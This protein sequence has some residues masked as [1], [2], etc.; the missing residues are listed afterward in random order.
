[1]AITTADFDVYYSTVVSGGV[2]SEAT[3]G[4]YGYIS[5]KGVTFST[6]T[7]VSLEVDYTG[8]AGYT[9]IGAY[10]LLADGDADNSAWYTLAWHE[11]TTA[12]TAVL[13]IAYNLQEAATALN[14]PTPEPRILLEF[15]NCS[16]TDVRVTVEGASVNGALVC[17]DP[18]QAAGSSLWSFYPEACRVFDGVALIAWTPQAEEEYHW[19]ARAVRHSGNIN[20]GT[21]GDTFYQPGS[22]NGNGGFTISWVGRIA[23]GVAVIVVSEA[24]DSTSFGGSAG[25]E[26]GWVVS[27]DQTT[28]EITLLGT[29]TLTSTYYVN[30]SYALIAEGDGRC[31]IYGLNQAIQPDTTA[32]SAMA[33]VAADGSYTTATRGFPTGGD[34]ST[35]GFW[36]RVLALVDMGTFFVRFAQEAHNTTPLTYTTRIYEH[37]HTG[38]IPDGNGTQRLTVSQFWQFDATYAERISDTEILIA[39]TTTSSYLQF[40]VLDTSTW[41]ISGPYEIGRTY[42]ALADHQQDYVSIN[43]MH[44][45]PGKALV[46]WYQRL[47]GADVF[48]WDNGV[49]KSHS[50]VPGSELANFSAYAGHVG[51]YLGSGRYLTVGNPNSG[52]YLYYW[53]AVSLGLTSSNVGQLYVNLSTTQE[54][55]NWVSVC[56]GGYGDLVELP[57]DTRWI[58][59]AVSSDGTA[60]LRDSNQATDVVFRTAT[61]PTTEYGF[62]IPSSDYSA[63]TGAITGIKME[64]DVTAISGNATVR[65]IVNFDSV[66]LS[67]GG[68]FAFEAD[69]AVTGPGTYEVVAT[70]PYYTGGDPWSWD[71]VISRLADTSGG[72]DHAYGSVETIFS[73]GGPEVTISEF[74]ISLVGVGGYKG[75]FNTNEAGTTWTQ[76]HLGNFYANTAAGSSWYTCC[77]HS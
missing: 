64:I 1:M 44:D 18:V 16:I 69:F 5:P 76:V 56:P 20:S 57:Q 50:R 31:L 34:A 4:G 26:L 7:V 37:T 17:A 13:S 35:N 15:Q 47:G 32:E 75:H 22:G 10:S 41:T 51:A 53:P 33:S 60:A 27:V 43:P 40:R 54:S 77:S 3:F 24:Y 63:F 29:V 6:E 73:T 12:G 61:S 62:E 74:R 68:Y 42:D 8:G 65:A 52:G 11:G 59:D 28:L 71:E 58:T 2:A 21:W 45:Q 46:T 9:W 38:G 30:G 67:G 25:N 66:H 36:S 23:E 49:P 48:V 19:K 72:Y 55:P 70:E 14:A 39:Y